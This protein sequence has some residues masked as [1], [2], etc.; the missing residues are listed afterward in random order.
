M[1]KINNMDNWKIIITF[2]YPHEAHMVKGYLES[3]GIESIIQDEMTAQVNNFYSNAIG[4]VKILVNEADYEQG[5]KILKK[6]GYINEETITVEKK[7]E[8]ISIEKETDKSHCPF[9]KSENIG[10]NKGLNVIA[11]FL[12]IVLSIFFPISKE[13]YQCFDCGKEWRYTRKK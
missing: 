2:T 5:I 1:N 6:G 7:I 9:C 12:Y 4:G 3:E 13:K 11:I 10:K 8:I